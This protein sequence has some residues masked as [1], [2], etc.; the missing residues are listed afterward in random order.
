[1]TAP[2]FASQDPV[3]RRAPRPLSPRQAQVAHLVA[4]GLRN[5]DIAARLG[6]SEQ[7]VKNQMARIFVK[8]GLRSRA[9]LAVW[10]VTRGAQ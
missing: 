7:T 5:Q 10:T 6:I 9:M 1:M 8:L 3:P 2:M 4:E